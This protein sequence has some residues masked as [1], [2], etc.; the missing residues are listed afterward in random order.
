M[1]IDLDTPFGQHTARRLSEERL[2][3]LVTTRADGQPQPSPVW[4]LWQD[5]TILLYSKPDQPK[6]RNIERQPKVS[7]HFQ[8]NDSGDDIVIL[9]GTAAIESD[10]PPADAVPAYVEKYAR[11]FER[12]GMSAEQFARS[13]SVLIRVT[14]TGLRGHI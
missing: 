1:P 5:G 11:G 6:S 7:L 8:A 3:W 14:P 2:I 12:I 13:Y 10:G 9:S 4:F